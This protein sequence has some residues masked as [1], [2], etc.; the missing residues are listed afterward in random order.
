MLKAIEPDTEQKT[1]LHSASDKSCHCSG[2]TTFTVILQ[3]EC[4]R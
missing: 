4:T 3:H 2:L 1:C